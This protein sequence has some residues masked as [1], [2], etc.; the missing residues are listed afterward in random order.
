MGRRVWS[1]LRASTLGMESFNSIAHSGK[2]TVVKV[3]L[4]VVQA[5]ASIMAALT[6]PMTGRAEVILHMLRGS[7][8]SD[9]GI[10]SIFRLGKDQKKWAGIEKHVR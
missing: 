2:K 1:G 4:D 7:D 5:L 6:L 3:F 8:F 10:D 9:D